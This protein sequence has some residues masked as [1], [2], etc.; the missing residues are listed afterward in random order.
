MKK[1][2]SE[3]LSSKGLGK[4]TPNLREEPTLLPTNDK[5]IEEALSGDMHDSPPTQ[6]NGGE[7]RAPSTETIPGNSAPDRHESRPEDSL[8][9]EHRVRTDGNNFEPFIEDDDDERPSIKRSK[10]FNMVV[11]GGTAIVFAGIA[12]LGYSQMEAQSQ[13]V[14]QMASLKAKEPK[15]INGIVPASPASTTVPSPMPTAAPAAASLNPKNIQAEMSGATSSGE[16]TA[17]PQSVQ[18]T[19]TI[20]APKRSAA[21]DIPQPTSSTSAYLRWA[22]SQIHQTS[23]P[24]EPTVPRSA[25]SNTPPSGPGLSG[26]NYGGS[27][28]SDSYAPLAEQPE[29]RY[30]RRS[31]GLEIPG[32]EAKQQN[33]PRE[34][35]G[36]RPAWAEYQPSTPISQTAAATVTDK[37][38]PPYQVLRVAKH[39]GV[40]FAYVVKNGNISTGRWA[41]FGHRFDSGWIL[42]KIDGNKREVSFTAPQGYSVNVGVE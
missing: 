3:L 28:S 14:Q 18:N 9:P 17:T 24:R 33:E 31:F 39:G 16:N 30:H 21:R 10:K 41:T 27:T 42:G 36:E 38:P 13:A 8:Q 15:I 26:Q 5:L 22:D 29:P 6:P 19:A 2:I 20:N 4:K 32:A 35:H 40:S 1:S 37:T 7:Q 12:Y 25:L 11:F 23:G 34:D